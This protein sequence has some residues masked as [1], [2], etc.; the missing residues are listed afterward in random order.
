M[1]C[2]GM[3]STNLYVLF[4]A[5]E[6]QKLNCRR[7]EMVT[8]FFLTVKHRHQRMWRFYPRYCMVTRMYDHTYSKSMDQPG[9]V[10]QFSTWSAEQGKT[11]FP[12]P[13][14]RLRIWSRETGSAVPSRVSLLNSILRLNLMLTYEIP[15]DFRDGVHLFI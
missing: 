3:V 10:C 4:Y 13:R 5:G 1:F 15:L 14:S 7:L 12:C 8:H 6:I 2:L 9:E 11:I